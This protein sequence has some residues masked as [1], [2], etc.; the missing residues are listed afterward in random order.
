MASTKIVESKKKLKTGLKLLV[1]SGL[2]A[3]LGGGAWLIY[4]QNSGKSSSAIAL[5]MTTAKHGTKIK[6]TVIKKC[7]HTN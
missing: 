6:S 4:I 5:P 3:L 2:L 7:W 1:G